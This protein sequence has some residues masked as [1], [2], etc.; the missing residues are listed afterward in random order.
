[1]LAPARSVSGAGEKGVI[2]A[3][4]SPDGGAA[5]SGLQIGDVILSVGDR[6]VNAPA[7]VSKILDE[8]HAH[9]KHV[10]LMHIKR[11]DATSFV[12]VPNG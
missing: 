1:M 10:I 6:A 8:A 12:A 11:A 3:G 2:I 9:S 4:I 5:D 7:D